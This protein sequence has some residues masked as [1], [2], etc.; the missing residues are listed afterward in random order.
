M[1]RF[2]VMYTGESIAPSAGKTFD[3]SAVHPMGPSGD[4]PRLVSFHLQRNDGSGDVTVSVQE[5]NDGTNWTPPS[6][7]LSLASPSTDVLLS[8]EIRTAH[9]RCLVSAGLATANVNG[10]AFMRT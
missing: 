3:V 6:G 7:V 1:G 9:V 4:S 2:F 5:S 8:H 10:F